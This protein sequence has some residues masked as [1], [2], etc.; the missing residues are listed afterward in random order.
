[1]KTTRIE[2][3]LAAAGDYL[4]QQAARIAEDPMTNSVFA[5]AQT[6][7]QDIE[8]GDTQLDEIASLIDEAHLLLVSQRAGR[9][10][11]QH[12][13]ARPDKAWAHVK[14]TLE[15]L[16]EKGFETFRT[17]LEQAR[18]GVVFTANP[19]F[20]L[21]PELRAAIA[22][23]AVSPGKP[24][25]QALEKALQADARGWNRAITLAS[26]HGE[27]QVALLNAAAAQQ[28][29]AS[30][31]FEV[32]Q[33][34]FPDDWRQLRPALPTIASWVGYDLDGRTD[35]HWSHSIAFRLTE[36]AEQLRRYH[37]RVQAILEHHPAAKGLV[38]LLER[39]DL[40]AGETALQAAMFTGDLQNP[41]HLVAA[42]NRLTAEG[43]GRLVDAAEIVSALDS[44]LAEAEGEESLARDLLILRSQVES[45]QLGTGRI[46]LRV[47]AA[48]IA[49]VISRELNLDADERSLG[50][51]ALAELSRRAAAPKP[52]DVNFADLFLE[53]STARR[54]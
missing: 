43:P 46:H 52:V 48:Q 3:T 42:A 35:I 21:S 26:E 1:M 14:T 11:E 28:Q 25:R 23:A 6:L 10:R 34:H 41:E 13:G 17:S 27:V 53:Q 39:L 7:F 54:R 33:A 16:A 12:G 19:T 40:A 29:F 44:A 8:R 4:R 9:L 22:G 15:T 37:A 49:T 18:G 38:P 31:V 2:P 36:K 47:N 24:A 20:S 51:M 45:Q 30:L 32:A 50:R 5:F